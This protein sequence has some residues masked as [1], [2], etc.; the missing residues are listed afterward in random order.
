MKVGS[1]TPLPERELDKSKF[2]E[3]GLPG[4]NISTSGSRP[5]KNCWDG[6]VDVIWHTLQGAFMPFPMYVTIDLGILAQISRM[7]FRARTGYY[8]SS[9]AWRKFEV[10]AAKDYKRDMPEEYWTGEEWKNDGDW[11]LLADCE[12]KRPSG[13][14][15]MI[16]TPTGEDLEYAQSGFEFESQGDNQSEHYR[17]LRIIIKETWTSGGMHMAEFYFYGWDL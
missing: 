3:V 7:K 5:L 11:S 16:G 15:E 17:Y 10:W 14:P 6:S 9:L 13:N 12:V 1:V 8:Y 2:L 4:D